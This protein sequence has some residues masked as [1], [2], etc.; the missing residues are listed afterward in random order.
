MVTTH[1]AGVCDSFFSVTHKV[2]NL[3]LI[4]CDQLVQEVDFPGNDDTIII[5]NK[6]VHQKLAVYMGE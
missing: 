1:A 4:Y 3:D 6:N 5:R 2:S